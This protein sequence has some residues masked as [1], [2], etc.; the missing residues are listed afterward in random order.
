M[1]GSFIETRRWGYGLLNDPM[2]NKG[3]AFTEAERDTF[4]LHGL[5]PSRV[6]TLDEQAG[7]RLQALRQLPT[8]FARYLFL[9][10]LQDS[11][12]VL[13]YKLLVSDLEEMLPI[14][15]TPTVGLGCQQFSR[16]FRKPRGVFLSVPQQGRMRD[17]FANPHF[18]AVEAIVVTDGERILGL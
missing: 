2:L 12:E 3:T 4:E 10:G 13:F 14:V 9:R 16:T 8:D 5:L 1:G 11:N 18:D 7:R 17:I 6:A 15:Y